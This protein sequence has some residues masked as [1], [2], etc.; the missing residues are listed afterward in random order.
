MRHLVA[1]LCLTATLAVAQP[2][3]R[4]GM[5]PFMTSPEVVNYQLS[6]D[7]LDKWQ[8]SNRALIP[9]AKAHADDMKKMAR[10]PATGEIK[11]IDDMIKWATAQGSDYIRV[12]E[13]GGLSFRDY[14]LT[15]FALTSAFSAE[16]M[17]EHG[18]QPMQGM[19]FNQANVDFVKANKD[20]IMAMFQEYGKLGNNK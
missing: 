6:L 2:P 16:M 13:S 7:K 17:M 10:P 15:T 8:A 3:Q 4:G 11:S 14:L 1:S 5:P 20:K 9:Y 18:Q 12:I 19:P